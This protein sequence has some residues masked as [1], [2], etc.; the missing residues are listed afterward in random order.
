M[1]RCMRTHAC[2]VLSI[3]RCGFAAYGVTDLC[4]CHQI[5][6]VGAVGKDLPTPPPPIFC[7]DGYDPLSFPDHSTPFAEALMK[8]DINARLLQPVAKDLFVDMRLRKPAGL[9]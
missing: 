7:D 2:K 8:S 3:G 9:L 1:C 5:T 4:L 6:F